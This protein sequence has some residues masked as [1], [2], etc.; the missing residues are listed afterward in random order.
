M[1]RKELGFCGGGANQAVQDKPF[2]QTR[3]LLLKAWLLSLPLVNDCGILK[4]EK[5]QY[6]FV[7]LFGQ[8]G[9]ITNFFGGGR[10]KS[11]EK[12]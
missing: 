10:G 4:R 8:P 2:I 9:R 12:Y 1:G 11:G 3:V 5:P 7:C 6:A